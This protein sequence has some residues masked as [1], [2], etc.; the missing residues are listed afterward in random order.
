MNAQPGTIRAATP[1]DVPAMLALAE[2][3][4]ARYAPYQ[5]KFWRPAA[6]AAEEQRPFFEQLV[7]DP[8][9]LTVVH[10]RDGAVD[11]YLIAMLVPP[12][13]VYEPG[14]PTCTIEEF[15]VADGADWEGAG[16]AML[17]ATIGAAQ[18][19][20]AVQAMVVCAHLDEAKR[21]MLAG[22]RFAVASETWVRDI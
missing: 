6:N 12:P 14:G 13:P 1:D 19:A 8:G 15:W 20:G 18:A 4:R 3:Q 16:R 11:G 17:E 10:E 21:A 7:A 2:E 22:D 5:P 9:V